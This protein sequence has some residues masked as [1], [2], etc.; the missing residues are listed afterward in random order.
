MNAKVFFDYNEKKFVEIENFKD[1]SE[2]ITHDFVMKSFVR[3]K[4]D[5][6][7]INY[8]SFLDEKIKGDKFIDKWSF[9]QFTKSIGNNKSSYDVRNITY[10]KKNEFNLKIMVTNFGNYYIPHF[11]LLIINNHTKLSNKAISNLKEKMKFLI[12]D[13]IL[14]FN[15]SHNISDS[16]SFSNLHLAFLSKIPVDEK[17]VNSIYYVMKFK[18]LSQ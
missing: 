17:I 16:I 11:N 15:S 7:I 9:E 4:C 1:E 2:I 13:D 14:C 3:D 8:E 6:D 18:K 12:V 5:G 10:V